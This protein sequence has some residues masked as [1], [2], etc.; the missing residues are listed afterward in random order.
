MNAPQPRSSI[1]PTG[2]K[3]L[4]EIL[5]GGLPAGRSYLVFGEPGTGKSTLGF[6]FLL[7]GIARGE[8]ALYV[9]FLQTR[10]ELADVLKTHGWTLNGTDVLELKDIVEQTAAAEQTLFNAADVELVEASETI[11]QAVA[12]RRP[13]RLVLDSVS[14]LSMLVS[15]PQ[16]LHRQL[17]RIKTELANEDCTTLFISDE[18]T[19]GLSASF[20]AVVHGA[21]HL[22]RARA[23][24]DHAPRWL[25]VPKMR[26]VKVADG[27]HDFAIRTGG[28]EVYPRLHPELPPD[29]SRFSPICSGVEGLDRMLGGGLEGGTTCLISGTTGCGKSTLASIYV[30]EAAKTGDHSSIFCFD[31]HPSVYIRRCK[32]LSIPLDEYIDRGLVTLEQFNAASPSPG[33]IAHTIAETVRRKESRILVIDGL[34]G[35]RIAVESQASPAKEIRRLLR[36]MAHQG[37][38][39]LLTESVGRLDIDQGLHQEGSGLADAILL[40]RHFEAHGERRRCIAVMKKRYGPHENTI[41]EIELQNGRIRI[42]DPIRAFSGLSGGVPLYQGTGGLVSTGS[43]HGRPGGLEEP[44]H[45]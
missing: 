26:G 8:K 12:E 6:Q 2:V 19:V 21:I 36:Y 5:E 11:L 27:T 13:D 38:T 10:S 32:S 28:L 37:V 33:E 17:L 30:H 25:Q 16:Q 29:A 43:S 45:D 15:S 14:E 31:E 44:G 3:G 7:E 1:A 24:R 4:D 40:L 23:S 22:G 20:Q 9:T 34:P 41:R 42:G 18:A 35:Y 39:V